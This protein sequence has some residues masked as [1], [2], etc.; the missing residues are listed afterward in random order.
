MGRPFCSYCRMDTTTTINTER[1]GNVS[2][3]GNPSA[4]Y[5]LFFGGESD[6]R[7]RAASTFATEAEARQA[8]TRRCSGAASRLEWAELVF[9]GNGRPWV[10]A[11]SGRPF[12]HFT[13]AKLAAWSTG[14]DA[15]SGGA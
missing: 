8:L 7:P 1:A 9:T 3:V 4:P 11:W 5:T 13:A 2:G 14:L 6:D 12:P 10:L 15:T